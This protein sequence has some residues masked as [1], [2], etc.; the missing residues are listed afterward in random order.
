MDEMGVDDSMNATEKTQVSPGQW[1][2]TTHWSVVRRAGASLSPEGQAALEQLCRAYWPPLYAFVRRQGRSDQD[3]E[4]LTQEFFARLLERKEFGGLD[5][6]KGKFRTF[7]LAALR[8][9]LANQRDWERAAKRGGGQKPLSLEEMKLER[10]RPWEPADDMTPDKAFD[11]RWAMATLDRALGRLKA[12]MEDDGKGLHFVV[13]KTFLTPDGEKA[14]YAEAS[15][16]LGLSAQT[17]AV[18]VHRLRVRYRQLV[19]AEVANTI[20]TSGELEEEMRHL[21]AALRR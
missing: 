3:A 9:F 14:D 1:F 2:Q 5:P 11:A 7:L 19:R 16:R 8:H 17:V 20:S 21:Y 13:L 12:E 18:Q 6:Q 15:T 10:A 4:D